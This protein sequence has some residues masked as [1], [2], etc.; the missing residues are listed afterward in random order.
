MGTIPY[1]E[2]MQAGYN[3][4]EFFD[5]KRSHP[6]W[7]HGLNKFCNFDIRNDCAWDDNSYGMLG[8]M[9]GVIMS[10]EA[11]H[12]LKLLAGPHYRAII[13]AWQIQQKELFA[14]HEKVTYKK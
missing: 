6:S 10:D 14:D 9:R 7:E 11:A 4:D 5:D 13:K 3:W 12:K 1:G 8:S 2:F